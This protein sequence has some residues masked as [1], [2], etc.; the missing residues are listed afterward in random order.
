MATIGEI[1]VNVIAKTQGFQ[2]G[3]AKS[4]AGLDKFSRKAKETEG[5]LGGF[6]KMLGSVQT[7]F[8]AVTAAAGGLV[9]T[10][11][12]II[13]GVS[14][15]AASIDKLGKAAEMLGTSIGTL[16]TFQEAAGFAGIEAQTLNNALRR[17]SRVIGEAAGGAKGQQEM[18][19]RLGLEFKELA[20]LPL[21]EQFTTIADA[22]N[23]LET[24]AEKTAVA[25]K[26]FNAQGV[27]MVRML[28]L[29]SGGLQEVNEKLKA[30]GALLDDA[31]HRKA[32]A[33]N[34]AMQSMSQVTRG[35]KRELAVGLMPV[36]T[37]LAKAL[38]TIGTVLQPIGGIQGAVAASFGPIGANAFVQQNY[39]GAA[40]IDRGVRGMLG[41]PS[42]ARG[43]GGSNVGRRSRELEVLESIDSTLKSPP[44]TG[45]I[46]DD[47][48][49]RQTI[50][51]RP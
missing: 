35:F 2:S 14:E 48:E 16:Q 23:R 26:V 19:K 3:M 12:R 28:E 44:P 4:S 32:A 27:E 7:K 11:N 51:I 10:V 21:A 29:G 34:D 24:H 9:V 38:D 45:S 50:M 40:G 43:A 36:L 42:A 22:M 30:S 17:M 13:T 39:G 18:F 47:Y 5:K 20:K 33:Y 1:A 8:L 6:N 49:N 46:F 37:E 25:G 41:D 31:A 15:Q